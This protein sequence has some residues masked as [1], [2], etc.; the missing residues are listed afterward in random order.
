[1]MLWGVGSAGPTL[2]ITRLNASQVDVS[3]PLSTPPTALLYF[4]TN[5]NP[6]V[7]WT[8]ETGLDVPSG[9]FHH[10]TVNTTGSM[11]YWTLRQ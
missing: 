4:T 2:A 11:K 10:V 7:T 9:G 5:L 1:L 8:L 6:P 3:W